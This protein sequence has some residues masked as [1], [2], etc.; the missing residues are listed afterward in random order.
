MGLVVFS[1]SPAVM[2]RPFVFVAGAESPNPSRVQSRLK[3]LA[4]VRSRVVK[5]SVE[6]AKATLTR[7]VRDYSKCASFSWQGCDEESTIPLAERCHRWEL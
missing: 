5:L 7:V 6:S 3:L 1:T 4:E 2:V